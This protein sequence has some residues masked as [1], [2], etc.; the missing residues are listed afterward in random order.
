MQNSKRPTR[1]P[2]DYLR[3]IETKK[4]AESL[5]KILEDRTGTQAIKDDSDRSVK[6]VKSRQGTKKINSEKASAQ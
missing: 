2:E 3:G 6:E 4:C 1:T 5:I